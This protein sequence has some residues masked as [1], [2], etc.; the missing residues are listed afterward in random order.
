MHT[1]LAVAGVVILEMIRRKDVYVL[2][3]L[4]GLITL[5]LGSVNLFGDAN[6]ARYLKEVCLTLI[7][8]S[9]VAIAVATA[10]RQIPAEKDSRTIFP[11][12][13]K[14][15]SRGQ[16]MVGKFLGCWAACGLS[17]VLFYSFFC[18]VSG[19]REHYWPLVN[20]FQALLLHCIFCGVVVALTLLGSVI[21]AAPS[22]TNTIVCVVVAGILL[23]GRHL[24]K[25]AVKA[26]GLAGTG[27]DALYFSIPHLEWYDVRDLIVHNWPR[28][29]WTVILQDT[30]YGAVFAGLFLLLAW[31]RF[32]RMAFN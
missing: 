25:V 14:P 13:A 30:L 28:M 23:L 19:T 31:V 7:W 24:H 3:F 11:L 27:L 4:T 8:I 1:I 18:L 2:L 12:L 32:R 16:V 20:Y 22:S 10:A 29:D 21:F 5:L 17:L 9:S 15:V 6:I 26:G